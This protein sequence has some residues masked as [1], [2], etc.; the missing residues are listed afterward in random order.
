MEMRDKIILFLGI[1][2]VWAY[3]DDIVCG[4]VNE[5][6]R[7]GWATSCPNPGN[8]KRWVHFGLLFGPAS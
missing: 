6:G 2:V 4:E 5:L 3:P 1:L 7:V 8:I